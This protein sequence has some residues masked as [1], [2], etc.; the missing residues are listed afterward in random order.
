MTGQ[1]VSKQ[2]SRRGLA[3]ASGNADENCLAS[4][5][6]TRGQVKPQPPSQIIATFLLPDLH[7]PPTLSTI[8]LC[9]SGDREV[10][11]GSGVT[12]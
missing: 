8:P 7:H 2:A 1:D 10:K 3:G 9:L 6:R 11:L 5:P 4:R 12:T